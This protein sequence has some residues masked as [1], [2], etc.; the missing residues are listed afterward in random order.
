MRTILRGKQLWNYKDRHG[1]FHRGKLD[2]GRTQ[3]LEQLTMQ[4]GADPYVKGT[5]VK[6]LVPVSLGERSLGYWDHEVDQFIEDLRRARLTK[7]QAPC[8]DPVAPR[9]RGRPRKV[10]AGKAG[11][12]SG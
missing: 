10:E 8:R 2:C 5:S 11:A 1:V 9:P 12:I 6:K 4:P 7:L 3:V